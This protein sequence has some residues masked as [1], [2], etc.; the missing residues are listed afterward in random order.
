[1]VRPQ[2]GFLLLTVLL[3]SCGGGVRYTDTLPLSDIIFR[4]GGGRLTGLVPE[5][6]SAPGPSG[7]GASG[8][9]PDELV[10]GRGDSLRIVLR[11]LTLDSMAASYFGRRGP[12][13]LAEVNRTL[14]DATAAGRS[15]GISRFSTGEKECAAYE[16][17]AAHGR[18]RVAIIRSGGEFYECEASALRKLADE[19]SYDM[20]FSVQ[21]SLIRSLR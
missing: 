13:D 18:I 4:A 6:W 20:L 2:T 15:G 3:A 16:L 17:V 11:G 9:S 19:K 7:R 14:R 8:T 10:I 5:G 21:Q 1:V 12:A